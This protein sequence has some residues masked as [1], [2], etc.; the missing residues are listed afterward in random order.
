LGILRKINV[1]PAQRDQVAEKLDQWQI[2]W[3]QEH[4]FREKMRAEYPDY[5]PPLPSMDS[6]SQKLPKMLGGKKV[7]SLCAG[8]STWYLMQAKEKDSKAVL[9]YT[10]PACSAGVQFLVNRSMT[11]QE[12]AAVAEVQQVINSNKTAAAAAANAA[13]TTT[14]TNATATTKAASTT[15]QAEATTTATA[16]KASASAKASLPPNASLGD[17]TKDAL[18]N[19]G[20]M[21]EALATPVEMMSKAA[22][23]HTEYAKRVVVATKETVQDEFWPRW[24][25]SMANA[26]DRK[27]KTAEEIKTN[28]KKLLDLT[29]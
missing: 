24:K 9:M 21:L 6:L 22:S 17:R 23:N 8:Y 10:M 2:R 29:K 15:T 25:Q 28:A 7:T 20:D 11:E 16:A 13:A 3:E 19:G 18:K 14:T 4:A 27:G 12:R 5:V 1:P 26:W